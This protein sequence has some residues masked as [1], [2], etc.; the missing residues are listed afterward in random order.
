MAI[1]AMAVVGLFLEG[2]LRRDFN[3]IFSI[4]TLTYI[5][6]P[7]QAYASI[8]GLLEKKEGRWIRTFKT[9][10]ITERMMLTELRLRKRLLTL[11]P[12]KWL[13]SLN[14]ARM[15]I[16]RTIL[17]PSE[18]AEMRL[19]DESSIQTAILELDHSFA[20]DQMTADEY[21]SERQ[22]FVADLMVAKKRKEKKLKHE[23]PVEENQ[24][25]SAV[26]ELDNFF[27]EGQ[28]DVEEYLRK[29]TELVERLQGEGEA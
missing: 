22:N 24:T 20:E 15:R 5:L 3:G 10:K 16:R 7:F 29:R 12:R 19:V 2:T 17:G 26:F 11:F 18:R 13:T 23:K 25:I 6:A 1:P 8:K 4:L 21:L 27:T 14:G 9:G 28:I